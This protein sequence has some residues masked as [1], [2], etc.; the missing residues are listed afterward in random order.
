MRHPL[1][2]QYWFLSNEEISY[3]KKSKLLE[4]YGNSYNIFEADKKELLR[5]NLLTASEIDAF[6]EKRSKCDIDR[7]Y[8]E[9]LRTGFSYF[10]KEAEGYPEKL[11]NLYDSV[12][13]FYYNGKLPDF[14]NSVAIVGAR[15]C[16][17]Y[18]KKVAMEL[19]KRLAQDGYTI[20][21]GMARGIDTYAHRGCL[22]GGGKTVAVLGSG[23]DVIY[24]S[25]NYLLYEEIV[26]NG[27]VISEYQ[28]GTAPIPANFPRRNRIVSALS[29]IVIVIEAREKSGSLITADLAL[30]QGKDIYVV[31]GRIGDSLSMGCNKLIS[32]GAGIIYSVDSFLQEIGER[33]GKTVVNQKPNK[34]EVKMDPTER[35]VYGLIDYYPKNL[36][37][38]LEET[39]MDHLALLSTIYSLEKKELI[40]EV[41]KNNYVKFK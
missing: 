19:S 38:L 4:Y 17:A 12:Y 16:S 21:S 5:S 34:I 25:E 3:G 36:S 23:C 26:K 24:P 11:I 32:Q 10:T 6:L 40:C 37:T 15:R 35:K 1:V 7:N 13:G 27:A 2:Y 20:I 33:Y 31:P 22:D 8:D 41:M 29:D 14:K 18:G 39:K 9:F 28:M 30:E